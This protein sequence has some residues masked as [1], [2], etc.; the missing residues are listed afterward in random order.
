EG[1]WLE[2]IGQSEEADVREPVYRLLTRE[3]FYRFKD[4]V[5]A[6]LFKTYFE[7]APAAIKTT[8]L[9]QY[10]M[11]PQIM[12]VINHFYEYRLACGLP[13]PDEQRQHHLTIRS[14][15][16]FDFITPE[17]H[18]VWVD[19]SR[20]PLNRPHYESQSGTSKV[21]FLEALLITEL[22]QKMDAAYREQGYGGEKRKAVGVISFY[23]KQVAEL[24]RRLRSL[25]LEALQVD[26]NTV[27]RFQG[28]ERPIILV[29]LVRNTRSGMQSKT[30]FVTQFE[31]I[32]VAFSR[33]QEL[34]VIFGARDMF[35]EC[36]VEL[37]LM[38]QPGMTVKKVY[39]EIIHSLNRKSNFWGSATV[40]SPEAYKQQLGGR[41]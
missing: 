31:R 1:S 18:A 10:R 4:M 9:T 17:S 30:A 6:S 14:A 2:V 41:G 28:K 25:R 37:P 23:G 13:K 21:N 32:N 33:A 15:E 5:T 7:H 34:L 40:I 16:G 38:D 35:A 20:D 3:N 11:H 29:S 19:S 26:V 39:G 36:E 27:D 12:E 24:R 22:L 8:L